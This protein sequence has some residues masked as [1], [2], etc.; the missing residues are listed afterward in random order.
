MSNHRGQPGGVKESSRPSRFPLA[1]ASLN[2]SGPSVWGTLSSLLLEGI[3]HLERASHESGMAPWLDKLALCPSSQ[4][5]FGCLLAFLKTP[6]I[7]E[8]RPKVLVLSYEREDLLV[9]ALTSANVPRRGSRKFNCL[10]AK[11]LCKGGLLTGSWSDE[12]CVF[13]G[14]A[15]AECLQTKVG[16]VSPQNTPLQKQPPASRHQLVGVLKLSG[17]VACHFQP[18]FRECLE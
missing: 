10:F 13:T 8:S 2:F 14:S 16:R 4:D 17:Q 15:H 11:V 12:S 7:H 6:K 3:Q 9:L 18:D 1:N 5:I